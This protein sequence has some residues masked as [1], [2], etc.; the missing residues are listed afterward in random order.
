MSTTPMQTAVGQFVW[1]D[2]MSGDPQ[3]AQDF[4]GKLLGWTYEPFKT[5]MGDYP[6][7]TK[8]G[9]QHG[10]FGPAQGGAPPHWVGHVVVDDADAAAKRAEA[11]G[12]TILAAMDMPDVGKFAVIRDP[13]GAVISA[14]EPRGGGG[15]VGE[16]AFAWDELHTRDLEGAKRFYGEDFGW[17]DKESDMGGMTYVLFSDGETDRAGAMGLMP[18]EQAPPYWLTYATT[19]DV[20]ATT[21]KAKDLG[22][23]VY[24]EPMDIT[25]IGRFSIVADPTG[26]VF[27]LFQSP[28]A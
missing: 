28:N 9:Q 8:N 14:F 13:Q 6:M 7:I 12:G 27:G 17:K 24:A 16:G 22:G 5:D 21:K 23:T 19:D 10:G 20:D 1:H 18:G 25:D 4:Y 11:A 2:H 26:A 15:S 3:Q